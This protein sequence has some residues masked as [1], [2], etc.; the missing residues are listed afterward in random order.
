MGAVAAV[1]AATQVAGSVMSFAEANKQK[2]LKQEA[3]AA[4]AK[5][6]IEQGNLLETNFAEQVQ[7][8]LEGYE[9]AAQANAAVQQQNIEALQ[10]AGDRSLIGG[11]GRT[12][13]V[14]ANASEAM[15]IQ[16]QQDLYN[17]NVRIASEDDK[18]RDA[19]RD[20]QLGVV[21]GAQQA[22]AQAEIRRQQAIAQGVQGLGG[23]AA[24]GLQ[25]VGLYAGGGLGGEKTMNPNDSMIT[26]EVDSTNIWNP[27]N[28]KPDYTTTMNDSGLVPGGGNNGYNYTWNPFNQ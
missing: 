7:V 8:P 22:A 14:G 25:G 5:A 10:Q 13:G 16:M 18:I 20:V 15:R 28:Q 12:M 19:K 11:V 17:R 27:N 6:M 4:A 24:T 21:Q 1:G 26:P 2:Q 3:D 9:L 23:A